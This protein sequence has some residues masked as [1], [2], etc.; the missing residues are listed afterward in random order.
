MSIAEW[1]MYSEAISN[2][3]NAE[4]LDPDNKSIAIKEAQFLLDQNE[5]SQASEKS[6]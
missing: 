1:A 2:V 6:D 4:K 5:Y 3:K